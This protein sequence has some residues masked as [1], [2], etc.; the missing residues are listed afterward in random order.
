MKRNSTRRWSG[1][2][3]FKLVTQGDLVGRSDISLWIL[4][5]AITNQLQDIPLYETIVALKR[6]VFHR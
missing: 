3:N 1:C 4:A 5:I 2:G 6:A